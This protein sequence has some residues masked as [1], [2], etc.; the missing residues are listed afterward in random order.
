MAVLRPSGDFDE[1]YAS[2]YSMIRQ[3]WQWVLLF[4][5]IIALYLL[6]QTDNPTIIIE[7]LRFID[8]VTERYGRPL[9]KQSVALIKVDPASR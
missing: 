9:S 5:T 2:D 7:K 3:R 8:E 4:L 6:P 1:S